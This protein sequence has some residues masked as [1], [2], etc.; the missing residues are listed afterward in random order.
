MDCGNKKVTVETNAQVL[1]NEAKKGA[2]L[3][4]E[5]IT[6][7]NSIIIEPCFIGEDVCL[8]NAVVGPH[9]SIGNGT[10][11]TDSVVKNSIIQH[12]TTIKNA[13]L[14]DSMIGSNVNYD[15][16]ARDLSLGDYTTVNG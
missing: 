13:I 2:Q 7:E 1:D 8:K 11:I 12:S 5:S 4:P 16:L 9:T 14:K 10:M 3:I 15:G 6:L